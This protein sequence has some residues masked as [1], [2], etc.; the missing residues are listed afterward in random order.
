M[1]GYLEED[2]DAVD[3]EEDD[4]DEHEEGVAAVED[5]DVELPVLMFEPDLQKSTRTASLQDT[6]SCGL[7][8][9]PGLITIQAN[10]NEKRLG[11]WGSCITRDVTKPTK[12]H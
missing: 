11:D 5:V 4:D 7:S 2:L 1:T 9:I 3:E 6:G 10:S 8:L 12:L